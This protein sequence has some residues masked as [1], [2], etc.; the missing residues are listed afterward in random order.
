MHPLELALSCSVGLVKQVYVVFFQAVCGCC[1]LSRRGVSHVC[2]C[3]A[4]PQLTPLAFSSDQRSAALRL[5][6]GGA[7][8]SKALGAMKMV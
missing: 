6:D 5:R 3:L 8:S 7:L 4:P 1:G 2:E